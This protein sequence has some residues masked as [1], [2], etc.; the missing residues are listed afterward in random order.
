[1]RLHSLT[2]ILLMNSPHNWCIACCKENLTQFQYEACFRR[3]FLQFS[4]ITAIHLLCGCPS[5]QQTSLR[6]NLWGKNHLNMIFLINS[7]SQQTRDLEVLGNLLKLYLFATN[8]RE[9]HRKSRGKRAKRER[10]E[11]L[12]IAIFER[13]S[14]LKITMLEGKLSRFNDFCNCHE[15]SSR[16]KPW[17]FI[18]D[19]EP[20]LTQMTLQAS[21][22]KREN[23]KNPSRTA[24]ASRK[25]KKIH[26]RGEKLI[27]GNVKYL[28]MS[29]T[30]L[31]C[32]FQLRS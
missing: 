2:L 5:A 18:F 8:E 31:R 21:D 14:V 4:I 7:L 9:S 12:F 26:C 30:I 27:F 24:R 11:W 19:F 6:P 29:D 15:I 3:N 16:R 23:C 10:R 28:L 32:V 25:W 22:I 13:F 20:L 17:T 1:M